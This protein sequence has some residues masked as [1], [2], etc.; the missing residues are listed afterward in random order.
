MTTF[1]MIIHLSEKCV[2]FTTEIANFNPH[3]NVHF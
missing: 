2:K 3:H 1:E